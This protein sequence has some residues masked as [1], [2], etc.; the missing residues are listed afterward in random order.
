V[1]F[2]AAVGH[3]RTVTSVM[4]F[5][6]KIRASHLNR[7]GFVDVTMGLVIFQVIYLALVFSFFNLDHEADDTDFMSI[8]KLIFIS[9]VIAPYFENLLL[10]GIAAVLEKLFN[11]KAMFFIAP[12][13][14]TAIHFITPKEFPF[15]VLFRILTVYAYFYIFLKQYDLHKLELGKHKALLLSSAVH[16]ALNASTLLA[17]YIFEPDIAAETIFSAQPG[18]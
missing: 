15:P 2:R 18:E 7:H 11:R 17:A 3:S 13:M 9:L 6:Q 12:L 4:N 14:L 1:D 8:G 16:T 5:I 10:I